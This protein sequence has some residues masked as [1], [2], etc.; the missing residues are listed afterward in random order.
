VAQA[1]TLLKTLLFT[2]GMHGEG[3]TVTVVNTA[4]VL[5]QMGVR[6][7]LIDADLRCRL[8][9]G[10]RGRKQIWPGQRSSPADGIHLT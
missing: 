10:P 5:A 4:A 1:E 7:L 3:K 2:S 6:V 8:P 9:Y